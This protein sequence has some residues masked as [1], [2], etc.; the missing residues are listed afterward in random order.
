[1]LSQSGAF[2]IPEQGD[3]VVFELA[4]AARRRRLE[5]W[6]DCGLFEPLAEGNRRMLPVLKEAGH[7]VHY[8]E[9]S[10]GHNYPAWRDDVWRGLEWLFPRGA[11]AR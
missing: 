5:V 1:V 8:R 11:A 6:M 3:F 7:R 9:Y 2:A 10:G 4:R